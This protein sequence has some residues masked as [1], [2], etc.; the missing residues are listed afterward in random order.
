MLADYGAEE[1]IVG[2]PRCHRSPLMLQVGAQLF[3]RFPAGP[4]PWLPLGFQML[5]QCK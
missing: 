5:P 1:N 4:N 3:P 2:A